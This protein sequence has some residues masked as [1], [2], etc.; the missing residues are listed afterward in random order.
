MARNEHI[1][2]TVSN[3]DNIVES[4]RPSMQER[5]KEVYGEVG[6]TETFFTRN[7]KLITFLICVAVILSPFVVTYIRDV[8][9]ARREAELP[10]MTVDELMY[11]ADIGG[12]LRQRDLSKYEDYREEID[13]QGMKYASYRIPVL[14]EKELYLSISFDMTMDYVFYVNLIDLDTRKELDLLSHA[15]QIEE[16]LTTQAN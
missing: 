2:T 16:F 5:Q 6:K 7:V 13:M 9:E 10:R 11:I 3:T 14:H 15:D 8:V 12:D 4:K 1:D